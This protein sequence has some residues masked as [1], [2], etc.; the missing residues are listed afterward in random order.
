LVFGPIL[1]ALLASL[2]AGCSRDPIQRRNAYFA[3]GKKYYQ[4]KKYA[5]AAIEFKNAVKADPR[6]TEGYYYLGLTQKQRGDL[7]ASLQA[8]SHSLEINPQQT[9]SELELGNLYLMGNHPDRAR[10][11]ASEVLSREPK[12]FSAQLLVAQS[13]L[14]QKNYPKALVELEKAKALRPSEAPIQLAIGIAQLGNGDNAAAATSFEHALA[15]DPKSVDGYRDLANL[16]QKLGQFQ[17]AEQTLRQGLKATSG[18]PELYLA[19]ADLYCRWGRVADAQATISSFEA[20]QKSTADL[21][22]GVGDFWVAHNQLPSALAEYRTA[23]S[24]SPSLLLKKK[25]VNV[26]ITMN[27]VSDAIHWNQQILSENSKDRQA[28]MFAGAIAHLQGRNTDAVEQLHKALEGDSASVFGH[29]YL[30]ISLMALGKNDSAQSQFYQCLKMDPSFSFAFL[31]L[32]QLSLH[33]GDAGGAAHYA[34]QVLQL[35]PS[36]VSGYILA[37]DAAILGGDTAR[38]QKALLAAGQLSPGSLAVQVRQAVVDGMR[39]DYSKAEREYQAVLS[40]VKDPTPL[41]AG[42]AQLYVAQ[43]QTG[44][45][46][47][48]VNAYAAGPG[49]NAELFVLLAQL[50]VLQKDLA[51]ATTDCQHALQLNPKSASAYFY[52]GRIAQLRGDKQSAIENYARAGNLDAMDSQS[53]LLAGNLSTELNRW[54]DAQDYYQRALQRTP[55][56]ASAQAGLARAMVEQG[57]DSN[58]ALGLAQQA[59]ASAPADPSIADTLGW[60]YLKKG[61][62]TLAIPP[63]QQAVAKMPHDAIFRFHLGLAYSAAGQKR[64]AR[65]TLLEARR[66]GLDQEKARQADETLTEMEK[67]AKTK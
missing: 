48:T 36:M 23:Y 21:H 14:A 29:Y 7:Q 63:L 19:M 30:G 3:N 28:L 59:R 55:G 54:A 60:V 25:F 27:D 53:E 31:Q 65:A 33:A 52:L 42:L 57:E 26:Y 51:T 24:L 34:R 32:G 22:S 46:I 2:L 64:E 18:A 43:K 45:A 38:A 61:M 1:L 37:A 44:K 49:A 20:T 10:D 62:A 35:D 56:I 16:H 39:R 67:R 40:R 11:Y 12:N 13:Y 17:A 50:H 4:E 58:V 5:D 66:L 9:P 15:L 47:Q 8:F 41:L 6:F